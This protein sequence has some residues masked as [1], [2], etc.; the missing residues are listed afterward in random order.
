M[1]GLSDFLTSTSSQSTT[2][3]T[4]YDAAQQNIANKATTAAGNTPTLQNTV[5]GQAINNLSGANNPF[6]QAQG[7][8]NTIAQGAANPWITDASG[9]VTP[10]T[11]TAMGGLFQA[12]NQQL[13]QLLPNATAP[14]QGANIASGN[15]GSLRGQTAVDKAKADAFANLNAAQMQAAL[16]NQQTGVSA[17]TGLSS[18][19]QQGTQTM[20]TLGQAQQSD[21]FTAAANMG[22]VVGG[23]NSP[24]TVTNATQLSPLQQISAM[25]AALPAGETA[26][27]GVLGALG[28][29]N[30]KSIVG[31]LF[32]GSGSTTPVF[33]PSKAPYTNLYGPT[34]TGGNIDTGT[35]YGP[36]PT[37]G[38]I[39]T[40]AQYGPTPTGGNID[41]GAAAPIQ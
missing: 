20:T 21:P 29:G 14:V 31:N 32:S 8:L 35:Q 2:M 19:G 28:L 13:N 27:N 37:G 34:P 10:N 36:T 26:A 3:P 15:F 39:D 12:Q 17:G 18:V 11:S 33:D 24:T 16:Q 6:T 5:A 4:W 9:N 25:L 38:N 1:A 40:G 7:S 23:L 30:I 22:K 41:S